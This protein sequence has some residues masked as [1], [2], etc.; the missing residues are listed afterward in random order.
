[1]IITVKQAQVIHAAL[2]RLLDQAIL[3]GE[4]EQAVIDVSSY[5]WTE[6][7]KAYN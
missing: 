2:D 5:I 4:S 7:V 1:M 3:E 6:L